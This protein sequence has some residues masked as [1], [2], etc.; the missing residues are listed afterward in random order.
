MAKKVQRAGAGLRALGKLT[1]N[2]AVSLIGS[3]LGMPAQVRLSA[4]EQQRPIVPPRAKGRRG[5]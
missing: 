5:R 4:R 1:G 2:P 3:A